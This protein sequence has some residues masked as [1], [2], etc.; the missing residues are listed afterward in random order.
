MPSDGNKMMKRLM[1]PL[2]RVRRAIDDPSSLVQGMKGRGDDSTRSDA[3]PVSNGT[4][5]GGVAR[6]SGVTRVRS[7][8][9]RLG[10]SGGAG[11][12]TA[13][14]VPNAR[15][16]DDTLVPS[17]LTQ[18]GSSEAQPA[19]ET[20]MA[21]VAR[22]IPRKEPRD[23]SKP[24]VELITTHD[25]DTGMRTIDPSREGIARLRERVASAGELLTAPGAIYERRAELRDILALFQDGLFMIS[26]SHLDDPHVA[27]FEGLLRRK[28]LQVEKVAV[29]MGI[30]RE[31]YQGL[32]DQS[33][34]VRGEA[35]STTMQRDILRFIA[36]ITKMRTSDIHI[37]VNRD[38]AEVRVRQDG[39]VRPYLEWR[40]SYGADFLAAIFAMADASDSSYQPYEYQAAR[41]S[42]ASVRLP[43]GLQAIRLQFNPLAYGGRHCVMRLLYKGSEEIKDVDT[44][45]YAPEQVATLQKMRALPMGINI[46]AGPT[47]SGKST[48]LQRSL[49]TLLWQR[50]YDISVF[51]VEDPPEYQIK[52]AQQ[53]PVTNAPTPEERA[54]KFSQ[55]ISA[56]LRSDPDVIM[57]GEI[58][59]HESAKLAFE[60]AMTGHQVW[61]TLHAT[62]AITI[63]SR[64]KDIGV[65]EFK[66]YDPGVLTGLVC[67]RLVRTTCQHCAIPIEDAIRDNKI[68]ADLLAR[69][70]G[71]LIDDLGDAKLR[72]PG[73]D[74]CKGTGVSGRTV[75][76]EALNPD[77]RFLQLLQ[78][79]DRP[80]ASSYWMKQDASLNM[81]LHA[82][83]KVR[84]GILAPDE[85]ERVLGPIEPFHRI[86][87]SNLV[88]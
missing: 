65:E 30:I 86:D 9:R 76:A 82:L 34:A 69:V 22:P 28:G 85:L 1:D 61:T 18:G 11:S 19:E 21:P 39:V 6:P 75:V 43:R 60:A 80:G 51:T 44:L 49:S 68:D 10:V 84:Q 27:S 41:V 58:R 29:E 33:A 66:L 4:E 8:A 38:T 67:Q 15:G 48:T 16:D 32:M 37:V 46:I 20:A 55:A 23:P 83:G 2:G 26:K 79:E 73:C 3:K 47:G 45:G 72:G 54:I 56:A 36:D 40:A 64:L 59:D 35:S 57:I 63:L 78:G 13:R 50:N 87:K 24:K 31:V 14:P 62:D 81:M 12:G 71:A 7:G 74:H 52:G 88:A 25:P 77:Q 17:S 70:S 5:S 53:M 42:D